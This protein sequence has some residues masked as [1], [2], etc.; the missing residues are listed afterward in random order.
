MRELRVPHACRCQAWGHLV[1][2]CSTGSGPAL[3]GK[4]FL[5]RRYL[6]DRRTDEL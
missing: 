3:F 2:R 4:D 6:T 1:A 5:V